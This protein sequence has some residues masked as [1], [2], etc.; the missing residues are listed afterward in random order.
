MPAAETDSVNLVLVDLERQALRVLRDGKNVFHCSIS[1]AA[2]G[3]GC[4]EGSGCTPHGWH[5]I[6]AVLGRGEPAGMRFVSREATGETWCGDC[7]DGDW[8]L[9]R[10]LW[11]EGLEPGVNRGE[12]VDSYGRYIYIHG[13]NHEERLGT[14]ASHGCVRVSNADAILLADHL[15]EGD[16]VFLFPR[17]ST[18]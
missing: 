2:N 9:S 14:P 12:G 3:I 4:R 8:I 1:S 18:P 6:A 16:L 5:R 10:I 17:G 11:L 7:V 15:R 13:T